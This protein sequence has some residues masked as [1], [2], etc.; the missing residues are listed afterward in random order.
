MGNNKGGKGRKVYK[1]KHSLM[2]SGC[3][4]INIY[5]YDVCTLSKH[6]S[7]RDSTF[8]H[9]VYTIK[10]YPEQRAVQKFSVF[11]TFPVTTCVL[12]LPSK[13]G[14]PPRF[15]ITYIKKYTALTHVK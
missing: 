13:V 7:Q 8:H 10:A 5:I 3:K 12:M 2:L 6:Q 15:S 14:E 1:L 4:T 9:Y 11:L